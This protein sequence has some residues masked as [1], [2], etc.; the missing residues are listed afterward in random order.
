MAVTAHRRPLAELV[1]AALAELR[2]NPTISSYQFINGI[3][4]RGMSWAEQIQAA[5]DSTLEIICDLI[6]INFTTIKDAVDETE[7]MIREAM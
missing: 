1:D 7:R 4:I 6:G 5:L 3:E 2:T